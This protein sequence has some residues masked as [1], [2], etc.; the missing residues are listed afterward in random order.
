MSNRKRTPQTSWSRYGKP[1]IYVTGDWEQVRTFLPAFKLESFTAAGQSRANP[2]VR[3]VVRQPLKEGE[4]SVPVAV[5]SPQYGLIQ[6][7]V[8]GDH[9]VHAMK[10]VGVHYDRMRCDL[11]M[12]ELGEWMHLRFVLDDTY[13]V[14]PPD[15]APVHFC[16]DLYNSVDGQSRLAMQTSWL[17]LVCENGLIARSASDFGLIDVHDRNVEL[18]PVEPILRMALERAAEDSKILEEWWSTK[19]QAKL[20]QWADTTLCNKW[21]RF[22]AARV[23]HICKTGMDGEPPRFISDPPSK[24]S[25]KSHIR[26]PG[27]NI[28]V[29]TLYDVAQALSWVA[30]ARSNL[31]RR[32][33]LLADIPAL[34]K[35][36]RK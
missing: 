25:V 10:R 9:V 7:R 5:V 6:H 33:D 32:D 22:N 18:G 12:T 16:I 17:R 11:E 20:D 21:G 14:S 26:V 19:L 1:V 29:A 13:S 35:E 31:A 36:L 34:V 2:Y 8:A 4:S 28:P 27:S 3:A 30:A 15:K 24:L 23:L